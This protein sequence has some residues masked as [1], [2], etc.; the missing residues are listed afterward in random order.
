MNDACVSAT[1]VNKLS[2]LNAFLTACIPPFVFIGNCSCF[3]RHFQRIYIYLGL[4]D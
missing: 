4:I 1:F 3:L 2:G